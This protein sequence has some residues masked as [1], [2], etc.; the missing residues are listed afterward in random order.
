MQADALRRLADEDKNQPLLQSHPPLALKHCS[1]ISS[2]LFLAD[3][4]VE[5]TADG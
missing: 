1:E 5:D 4:G 3:L 2:A